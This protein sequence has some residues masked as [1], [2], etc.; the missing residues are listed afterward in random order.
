MLPP[1]AATAS[2]VL[3][4]KTLRAASSA[5]CHPSPD[6]ALHY[7]PGYR[8]STPNGVAQGTAAP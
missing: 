8:D 5:L 2:V 1:Q 7:I 6:C 4:R 3:R